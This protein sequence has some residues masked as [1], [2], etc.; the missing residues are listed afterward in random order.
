[1]KVFEFESPIDDKGNLKI[2]DHLIKIA[3][4]NKNVRTMIFI[5]EED[6]LWENLVREQ[7]FAGYSDSDSIYDSET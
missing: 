5:E 4:K 2:P 7:F 1:M 3:P 6:K